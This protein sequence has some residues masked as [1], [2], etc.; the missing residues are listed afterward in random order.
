[1]T[2]RDFSIQVVRQL[3]QAGYVAYW[4]GGCVRD[5]LLGQ[6]PNDFDVATNAT[7]DQVRELFG[8]RRTLAVG[9]S[10]G[11]II[12]LGPQTAGQIEV[13]TFRK[14]G[15][16]LDG[17]RPESVHFCSAAE[18]AQRRDFT[19]NGMFYDPLNATVHDFVGG[20]V[21]LQKQ[22]VRAIGNPHDR[23]EEDKL[24]MLRAARFA[25]VLDF[26]LDVETSRAVEQMAHQI[27][28]VSAERITQ[29][30]KKMLVHPHRG[31]AVELCERLNLLEVILPEVIQRT[32]QVSLEAWEC[33]LRLL[34][35]LRVDSFEIPMAALLRDVPA[36]LQTHRGEPEHGTVRDVCRR[37]KL[38]NQETDAIDWLVRHQQTIENFAEMSLAEQKRLVTQRYFPPL[39]T[40][41]AAAATVTG[42]SMAPF[43]AVEDFFAENPPER[44]SP[45]E[46]ING[47][48]LIELGYQPGPQ[49]Q[50]WLTA[51]RDAQLNEQIST[52]N[53]ALELIRQLAAS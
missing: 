14:E 31:R 49:F 18:D 20:Q 30:L 32:M 6:D 1:M 36:P 11:V 40:L 39:L 4:A 51:V 3:A 13:A 25:T 17:R 21:D 50:I 2:P 27:V 10:F 26:S 37:L 33:R 24:R 23:M 41:E 44:L 28:V 34:A 48:K 43:E 38:S 15:A 22:I 42:R 46:L 45:P 19:I 5:L 8:R 12:V 35:E 16:Y 7:P 52:T 47:R 9:E 53:E 29:E